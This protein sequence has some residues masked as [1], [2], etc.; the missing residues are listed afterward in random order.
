MLKLSLACVLLLY[1]ILPNIVGILIRGFPDD[2]FG[3][4]GC[5]APCGFLPIF[6]VVGFLTYFGIK[7]LK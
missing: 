5:C 6:T 1:I 3:W 2:G 7:E 4:R